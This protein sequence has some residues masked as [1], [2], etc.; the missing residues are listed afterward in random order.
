MESLFILS[1]PV[2]ADKFSNAIVLKN[3][4]ELFY[5]VTPAVHMPQVLLQFYSILLITLRQFGE[6][7]II[8]CQFFEWWRCNHTF[9]MQ[10]FLQ[11]FQRG[12]PFFDWHSGGFLEITDD[13]L[14]FE[15]R[16]PFPIFRLFFQC[17]VDRLTQRLS[18][19]PFFRTYFS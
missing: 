11:A 6:M 1:H 4:F 10:V 3:L 8:A 9:V 2:L 13:P 12:Q 15:Q 18:L 7:L 14:A 19:L 17:D 5:L 16:A